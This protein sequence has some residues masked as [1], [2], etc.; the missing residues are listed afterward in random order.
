MTQTKAGDVAVITGAAS[1]IGLA[2]A[3]RF[4]SA[5]LRVVM[6]DIDGPGVRT[7]AARLEAS[8]GGELVAVQ[9]DVRSPT[10]VEALAATAFDRFDCVHVLCNNAGVVPARQL[11]WEAGLDVWR[12][13]LEVDLWGAIH[14]VKAFLPRMLDHGEH[15]HVVNTA[16][17]AGLL[18]FPSVAPYTV[19][20]YGLVGLSETLLEA[21]GRIGA[22]IGV[23]VLCPGDV[24]TALRATSDRMRPS[25]PEWGPGEGLDH[26]PGAL[27]PAEIA[28]HVLEAI[29][30]DR[31]WILPHGEFQPRLRNRMAEL[32]QSPA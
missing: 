11:P 20:K 31:F 18:P 32:V 24:S 14:G 4:A 23:S 16:S 6:A 8:T 3:E 7:A 22:P 30:T 27:A 29:R 28:A 10:S 9:S 5:G 26:A 2:L 19:A 12:W 21:L 13:V 1:G 17:I 25:G 15:G